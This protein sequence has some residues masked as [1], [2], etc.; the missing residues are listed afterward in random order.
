MLILKMCVNMKSCGMS[1]KE[2]RARGKPGTLTLKEPKKK[3]IRVDSSKLEFSGTEDQHSTEWFS[4]FGTRHLGRWY[5]S[6]F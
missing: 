6:L 1:K 3:S 4:H 2:V 5:H